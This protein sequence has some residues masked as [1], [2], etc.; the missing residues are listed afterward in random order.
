M[1]V[2]QGK[3]S[4]IPTEPYHTPSL[5]AQ[6]PS[7][8]THSSPL[9]PPVTT[10]SIPTVIPS[11]TPYLSE[12]DAFPT[13][14]GFEADQDRANIAKTSTMPYESTSRVT[15]LVVDEGTQELE[16]NSLKERIKLL[17]DKD[18]GVA[19]H[20]GDDAPIKG[21]WLD[22]GEEAAERVS[23]DTEEMETVLTS[24]NVATVLASGVAEVPTCSG[25]IPTAGPPT[26]RVPTGSDVVP[27]AEQLD[28][29]MARQ[30]EE[31]MEREARK[32]NEQ[33]ARYAEIAKIHDEE[34]LQIM[35]DR[36]DKSNETVAKKKQKRFKRKVIRFEQESAKKLKTS[37]EVP[38]EVK[39]HDEVPKEKV[40]EM[41]QL[42]PV[43][44][45]Y[46][47]AL[48]VKHLITDWKHLDRE[49]LNQLWALVKE[50]LNIRP[51]SSDKE[52]EL[53]VELKRLY[54]P[55]VE[56]QLWTHT[57]NMM[58]ALVKW[59]LYDSCG[60]H[61]V[62]SKDN[63]IFML[64]EKDY[65]LRKGLA[66]VM[67]SYKLQV[68]NYF[69]MANDLILKIYKIAS[70]LRQQVKKVPTAE[71]KQCHCCEDCTATKVKKKLFL[72]L[73]RLLEEIHVTWAHLE[74]KRTRLRTYTNSLE[75]L[76]KQCVETRHSG[77][78]RDRNVKESWALL[79]DLALYDNESWN[80]PWDFANPVK[81][82]YL[83]QDVLSTSN[84]CLIELNSS[85]HDTQYCMENPKQAFVEYAS[86]CIDEA[87]GLVSNFMASQDA[88]LFKFKADF[89]QQ[90][91]KMT[92]KID[93]VLKAITD[94]MAGAL[95][96]DTVK[97]PKLNVNTTTLGLSARSYPTDDP[98]C[99]THIHGLINTITIH[100]KQQ[101]IS[102]YSMAE[103]EEREREADPKD[104]NT[105]TY[106]EE[107]RYTPQLE[108]ED[109]T[110]INNL[111]L[112]RDD[113]R[114][115]WLDVEETLDLV[116][117][118]KESVYESLIKEMPKCLLNY[119]FISKKTTFVEIACLAINRKYGL[120]TFTDKTKEITFKTPYKDPERSK[121]SRKDH[122]LLSSRII[123]SEDD[124]N[125]GCKKPSDLE[126]GF[127]RDT[128]KL[129]PEYFTRMDDK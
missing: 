98:Q 8:T 29:Q 77:K 95:P 23:N 83:P 59:K 19:E 66:I 90:Q 97:N 64:I 74:K 125:R 22:V 96:S 25:F 20:S 113:K 122:D 70:S 120:M 106:N 86:L 114:I 13:D 104:T 118:S 119:D 16:I 32:M 88:R 57:H 18:R 3:G 9:L 36:L 91:S 101:I 7:P 58:H 53:W 15:S 111:R 124:Y 45:V 40:K 123:L 105:I 28:I 6:Q 61:R 100:P 4:G 62:T 102:S 30:L 107:Q 92:N 24:M 112:N 129:G 81:A 52:M 76:C 117:T 35:I 43:E 84:F 60:V 75:D 80:D 27:T 79:E 69:Q 68:E 116:D 47:E 115:E 87:R 126:H 108:W 10:A 39:S 128:I 73:G 41:M 37:E 110:A 17:D 82:I 51:A 63:K 33:I 12:G 127:Y 85:P 11:D 71:E 49:D 56:D 78:L 48:Q 93:T 67:I 99:S 21:S 54:E 42:V 46:V 109:I 2:P 72:A 89:K 38:E 121:L 1:L 34:E 44:E 26:T 65:P 55:D 31:E 50:S 14:S 5:E 103:E 94:L